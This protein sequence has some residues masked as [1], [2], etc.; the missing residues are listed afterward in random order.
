MTQTQDPARSRTF[1]WSDP[2]INAAHV[3]RRGGL[4]L[5]RAMIAGELAAPP[6]MHL[7]DMSRMEAEEGWVAV[8]LVPQEFHY[9]PLG[10]VHGG[11][12]STLLDTAAACAVHTTLPA[13]IGYT[14]L[15]LN[16]KFLR[17]VT[18]ASGTLRCEGTVLQ[19]GRRTSLAEAKLLDA[20]SRL[21]AHATSTCLLYPLTPPA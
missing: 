15:D 21:V 13:G 10:T 14:S 4:D 9:N 17:P 2:G 5:L 6:I 20:Q 7:V 18:V 3:G 16:V 19:R 11:V 8:E 1:S 12:I